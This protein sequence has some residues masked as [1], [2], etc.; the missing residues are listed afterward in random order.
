MP[1]G[2]V[3]HAKATKSGITVTAQ[4]ARV[5]EPG[6]LK[7]LVD[8]AW[9]SIK[10]QLVRGLSIGFRPLESEPLPSG[11]FKFKRWLWSEL[12]LVTIAAQPDA[13][14]SATRAA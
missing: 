12:S 6:E 10:H 2:N 8:R 7:N 5:D 4:I 3:T 1:V 14:I 13:V 9:H 11:G